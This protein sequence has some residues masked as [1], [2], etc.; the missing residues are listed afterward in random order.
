MKL[1]ILGGTGNS[2]QRLVRMALHR[3]HQVTV[4]VRDREKLVSTVGGT[5]ANGLNIIIGA[6]DESR[7]LAT[8]M[9]GHDAVINAAGNV[10]MGLPS[11]DWCVP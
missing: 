5:A 2:G 8:A 10:M 7:A 11:P 1:F 4:F 9:S 3:S 6:I